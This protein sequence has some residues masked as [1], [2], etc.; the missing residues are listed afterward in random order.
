M[1]DWPS[2]SFTVL[3]AP[4]PGAIGIIQLGGHVT[5]VL[6]ALTGRPDW[7]IGRVRLASLAKVDDGLVVRLTEDIAQLMPHGGPR[8]VQRL[9]EALGRCGAVCQDQASLDPLCAHPEAVD[10]AEAC[11]LA[12]LARAASPLATDLLIRQAASW[13]ETQDPLTDE[14][15]ARSRRLNRL[16]DPPRVVLAGPPNTGKSS[17]SN[18]LLGR[19][20]SIT[21]DRPGTTRDYT[22]GRLDLAG[23]V[24][25]WH[26]TPGLRSTDDAIETRAIALAHRVIDAADLLIALT[27]AQH[28]WPVLPRTPDLRVG[29]KADLA[30]RADVDVSVS[31]MSGEGLA[32]LAVHIRDQLVPPADRA[33][34]GRWLFDDRL[35]NWSVS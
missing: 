34:R 4:A 31:A 7:P 8:V 13:R 9:T 33:H 1:R 16:I 19:S 3:T 24:V 30:R 14:D 27:D 32:D 18:A 29:S 17:L 20:M 12:A 22:A 21:L 23:L 2:C 26:D 10:L 35:V 15:R 6:E 25:D 5:P 28:D 11:M